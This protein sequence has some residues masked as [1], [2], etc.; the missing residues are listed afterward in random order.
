MNSRFNCKNC[1]SGSC[2]MIYIGFPNSQFSIM[3]LSRQIPAVDP[4]Y[5]FSSIIMHLSP[6]SLIDAA[7]TP[8]YRRC[9]AALP[10][11]TAPLLFHSR[12]GFMLHWRAGARGLCLPDP[13]NAPAALPVRLSGVHTWFVQHSLR[14]LSFRAA[15]FGKSQLLLSYCMFALQ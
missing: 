5:S 12:G 9:V 8:A 6:D 3:Y 10:V 14:G 15:S 7:L 13:L 11:A 4:L 2:L 1:S